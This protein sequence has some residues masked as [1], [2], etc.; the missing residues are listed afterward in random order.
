MSRKQAQ[1]L[2]LKTYFTGKPCK[3]GHIDVRRVDGGCYTCTLEQQ[4][5]RYRQNPEKYLEKNKKWREENMEKYVAS[6]LTYRQKNRDRA[7][8]R[9]KNW[10]RANK[11]RAL[12]A[13]KD[14]AQ[15]N[16][17]TVIEAKKRYAAKNP[18]KAIYAAQR[19]QKRIVQATPP[20][21][22][23]DEIYKFYWQAKT[24]TEVFGFK[25]HVD[26]IVPLQNPLV[27]GLHVSHNLQVIPAEDNLRKSNRFDPNGFDDRK[28]SHTDSSEEAHL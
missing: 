9:A 28:P 19:R 26:H 22:D 10:Y 5:E 14:W 6:D 20:W 23:H 2:G 24:K 8:A 7:K 13:A 16:K 17:E 4:R 1:E 21:V 12:K 3:Y 25:F 15:R 27:C 11:R 18:E